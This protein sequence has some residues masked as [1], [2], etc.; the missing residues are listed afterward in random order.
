MLDML[1]GDYL[2]A[3]SEE[4]RLRLNSY[5]AKILQ[6]RDLL[7]EH[8]GSDTFELVSTMDDSAVVCSNGVFYRAMFGEGGGTVLSELDVEVFN[9]DN[10]RVFVER[11]SLEIA[12]LF[13]RG[14][15]D[16]S[17][18]K[19]ENV[20][21][22]V[23][24]FDCEFAEV[25]R[26]TSLLS[27]PRLWR[28]V[29][30]R[31]RAFIIEFLETVPCVEGASVLRDMLSELYDRFRGKG[32]EEVLCTVFKDCLERMQHDV[33]DSVSSSGLFPV[34]DRS[35]DMVLGAYRDFVDDL[36]EDL[37]VLGEA[38]SRVKIEGV[39]DHALFLDKLIK[40]VGD[41]AVASCFI[42]AANK[43]LDVG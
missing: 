40:G 18:R 4:R 39:G 29:F 30:D 5:E 27:A 26:L 25:S 32:L 10:V 24:G 21:L 16:D 38:G 13:I 12:D 31:K 3:D 6:A 23:P 7:S 36:L 35:S 14:H 17:L 2:I 8:F 15:M 19:L 9:R 34:L 37:Y 1:V 43:K 41:R 42:V 28:R 33:V 20:V 11:E 22:N